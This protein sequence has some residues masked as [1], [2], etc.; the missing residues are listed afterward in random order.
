MHL[1]FEGGFFFLLIFFL[2]IVAAAFLIFPLRLSKLKTFCSFIT[3]FLLSLMLYSLWGGF[4]LWQKSTRFEAQKTKVEK[5]LGSEG[6][7]AELV[8]QLKEQ[9]VAQPLNVRAWYLL[10]R[11]EAKAENWSEAVRA[12][13]KAYA[14]NP[15][16]EGIVLQYSYALLQLKDEEAALKMRQALKPLLKKKSAQQEAFSL[17]ALA[18]FQH[19]KP[20]QAIIYWKKMMN[21]GT[22]S[23]Q[24]E[25]LIKQAIH[26]AEKQVKAKRVT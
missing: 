4:G 22:L 17:L 20:E 11:I 19:G 12:L 18:A 10:G 16:D 9:L 5:L 14:L 13:E 26:K 24:E 7:R 6:G 8:K 15:K 25:G 1:G 2:L 3:L 21:L 23:E